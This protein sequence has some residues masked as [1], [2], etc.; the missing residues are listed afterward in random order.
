MKGIFT[1]FSLILIKKAYSQCSNGQYQDVNGCVDCVSG[2][3]D[4]DSDPSTVCVACAAGTYSDAGST[5]CTDCVAGTNDD[6]SDPSTACENCAAGQYSAAKSTSCTDCVAGTNDDD[7]D[8]STACVDCDSG[9]TSDAGSTSCVATSVIYGRVMQCK[10]T[11]NSL[12]ACTASE[13]CSAKCANV[14]R[15]VNK[16]D[17]SVAVIAEADCPTG[18]STTAYL[19]TAACEG[20][21]AP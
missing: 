14:N 11:A 18:I 5:S 10:T 1:L 19:H 3:Y 13:T 20:S 15:F 2:T 16:Q 9:T 17:A 21:F 6:D 8:P 4:D 7:S 12:D